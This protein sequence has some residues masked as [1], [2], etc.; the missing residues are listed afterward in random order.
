MGWTDIIVLGVWTD[1]AT[2]GVY[3]IVTRIAALTALI[4]V[5]VNSVTAPRFAALY[6]H[7][8]HVGLERL[9]Q[10]STSW[11]LLAALPII[12]L[13]LLVPEWILSLFG[14]DFVEGSIVL[15]VLALGQL[16]N[17]A[18]GSV[19][20]LLMMTGHERLM[21]NNVIFSALLNLVGNIVLVPVFGAIG[22]A[23]STAFSLMFMNI[24]SFV[25]VHKRLRINTMGGLFRR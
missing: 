3:A 12:L 4:L 20:Y 11:I 5:V 19:T 1:S 7:D 13:L 24:I 15:R 25:L 10:T 23:V 16:V 9:A 17:V 14:A 21:R 18:T 6:A 22:A 2:V 8:D